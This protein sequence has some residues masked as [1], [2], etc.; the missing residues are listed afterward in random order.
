MKTIGYQD[1]KTQLKNRNSE[2]VFIDLRDRTAF[3]K[4]HIDR[5]RNIP[6]DELEDQ[7]E[8]LQNKT[9]I[10]LCEKGEMA[11]KAAKELQTAFGS[12]TEV[13]VYE[14]GYESWKKEESQPKGKLSKLSHQAKD[15]FFHL[16][17]SG[18]MET[19]IGG[20]LVLL[21]LVDHNGSRAIIAIIGLVMVMMGFYGLDLDK[22]KGQTTENSNH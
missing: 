13:M 3:E 20:L 7:T 15:R 10:F 9:V 21:S 2:L 14:G 5:F 11:P 19:I 17:P 4:E 18:Q 1:L 16:A 22:P 8:T 12:T 6:F